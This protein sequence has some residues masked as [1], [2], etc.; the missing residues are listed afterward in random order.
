[1]PPDSMTRHPDST[2]AL[3]LPCNVNCPG[4]EVAGAE[5]PGGGALVTEAPELGATEVPPGAVG[6]PPHPASNSTNP[7]T[8]TIRLRML[9]VYPI[10]SAATLCCSMY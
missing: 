5:L 4:T 3:T 7:A 10:R 8:G 6:L 9:P 1:M 2:P